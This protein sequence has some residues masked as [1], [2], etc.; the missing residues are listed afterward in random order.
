M[1]KRAVIQIIHMELSDDFSHWLAMLCLLDY[2]YSLNAFRFFVECAARGIKDPDIPDIHSPRL[3]SKRFWVWVF[4]LYWTANHMD[5]LTGSSL[6]KTLKKICITQW[7]SQ[8]ISAKNSRFEQLGNRCTDTTDT[9]HD[10]SDWSWRNIHNRLF[11]QS[12]MIGNP[13]PSKL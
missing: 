11:I 6:T 4:N 13:W 10:M 5:E 12:P 9:R 7:P 2:A 8:L 1:D 3:I